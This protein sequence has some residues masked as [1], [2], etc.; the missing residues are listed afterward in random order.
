MNSRMS[1]YHHDDDAIGKRVDK[2]RDNYKDF[3]EMN[4]DNLN[5][6]NN[7]SVL[8][9]EKSELDISDIR[10]LISKQYA[11]PRDK[12]LDSLT[13]EPEATDL[14]VTKEY[15]LKDAMDKAYSERENDYEKNR[16]KK[17]R[18]TEYEILKSINVSDNDESP[19]LKDKEEGEVL[20]SL[21]KT[22]DENALRRS[23]QSDELLGD[24]ISDSK[25]GMLEPI[26][27]DTD[28]L[29]ITP[30]KPTLVE[31]LERTKQLSRKEIM[32]ELEQEKEKEE[33]KIDLQP[34]N[35]NTFYTGKLSIEDGDLEDFKDLEQEMKSNGLLVKVLIILL[36]LVVLVVA[37]YLLNKYLNLGLF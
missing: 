6:T 9:T 37:A 22:I 23:K 1:K 10:D 28:E 11:N 29:D 8:N 12:E 36:V 14:E 24:L 4:L 20:T 17:L 27:P 16:Y 3:S 13:L 26:K 30:P 34:T 31:E 25:T 32:D 2:N 33:T 7:V 35:T 15:N 5:L 21:L 18:D 19:I